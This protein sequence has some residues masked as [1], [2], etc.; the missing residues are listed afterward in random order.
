[1]HRPGGHP[2]RQR[3][4][5]LLLFR[6]SAQICNGHPHAGRM[7]V[8]PRLDQQG[9]SETN[10]MD[11]QRPCRN[12]KANRS[13][14]TSG[15]TLALFT[16]A[17]FT[18]AFLLFSVQ[19]MFTR[20]VLPKLG[21]SPSVWSVA[22]VFFQSM[23]LAGYGYAHGLTKLTSPIRSAVIH[24]LLL[25]AAAL[26]LPLAIAPTWGEP[27]MTGEAIW[28]IGLFTVSIG[29]PFFAMS[30]NNPLLQSWFA[31]TG[32]PD[33]GDPY[34]LYAASNL[35]SFLALL[36]YPFLIEPAVSLR[37]QL[38]TW[39]AGFYL[40]VALIAGCGLALAL[41]VAR[42]Q[43]TATPVPSPRLSLLGRWVF[44]SA[45]PSGLLVAVTAHISTDVAAAPLLWVIPLSLYLLTW[46]FVFQS[47]PIL[48]HRWMLRLHPAAVVAVVAV[49]AFGADEN[50][51]LT[52][53]VHLAAFFVI[54]MAC[55]GE[56]ARMRPHPDHLTAFYLCLSLGGM[57]GGVFAALV[58][59]QV[60][61]W[62]AEYPIL[63]VLSILCRPIPVR[64][65][66]LGRPAFVAFAAVVG[67][68]LMIPGLL[69]WNPTEKGAMLLAALVVVAAAA[70]LFLIPRDPVKF[71]TV[72]ALCLAVP[73]VYPPEGGRFQTIRSFFGVHKIQETADGRYRVL[74]HGTTIHGAQR[75][76]DTQGN[77][78]AGR[79][80]PLTYYHSDFPMAQAILALRERKGAPLRVSVVG[81][82]TG[83]LACYM[84]PGEEWSFFEID[85]DVI[86]IARDPRL[87]SFVDACAPDLSIIQ[88]DAR[89]TLA[90][91]RD[92]SY[93]LLIVD[94]FSS[95]SVPVHLMTEEAMAIYK[96]KLAPQG[97][98]MMHVSNRHLELT[99]VVV[100]IAAAN[101]LKTWVSYSDEDQEREAE[102][103][104]SPEVT[105]SSQ[106]AGHLGRLVEDEN[107]EPEAPD[108]DRKN[109]TDDYSNILGAVVRRLRE[110]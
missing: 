54:S 45:V 8:E 13:A 40:V 89:L 108:P 7:G 50:L 96:A 2:G 90:K 82:G 106:E 72:V 44:V 52:L 35:G 66:R 67:A 109:W 104:F 99:S 84:A 92:G 107:W 15:L 36:S 16:A 46:I 28:L 71:G 61:S 86:R 85:P 4:N 22:M 79:P 37:A 51:V 19:P 18:S 70:A 9:S 26:T 55:H 97:A 20:M 74:M 59:P 43:T 95:D 73:V 80:E 93:D 41:R 105:I 14:A 1:M 64:N 38:L 88:G 103:I 83:S 34:F 24:L 69:G 27:P 57:L 87:F 31:R 10:E 63:L 91:E 11:I 23:L 17:V 75:L 77:P 21:G 68:A 49:S 39:S 62:I 25:V 3:G 78:L 42:V 47:R 29:L 5:G 6:F 53:L 32:H 81:L 100:G 58:A 94:A 101:G 110:E 56:L 60:F 30:A 102:Y 76:R 98:V 12:P 65:A 33:A 48:P